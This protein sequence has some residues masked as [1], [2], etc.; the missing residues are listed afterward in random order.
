MKSNKIFKCHRLAFKLVLVY[1]KYKL[2]F[3]FFQNI[4]VYKVNKKFL[5]IFQ[6]ITKE[7]E[8]KTK[9]VLEYL[10]PELDYCLKPD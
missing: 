2:L 6:I 7:E 4:N 1:S 10:N 8:E 5:F 9:C 3:L